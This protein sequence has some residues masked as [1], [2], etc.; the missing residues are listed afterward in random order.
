MKAGFFVIFDNVVGLISI[1]LF[2]N[3]Y[4]LYM[5][6][7]SR[8]ELEF[9]AFIALIFGVVQVSMFLEAIE[10]IPKGFHSFLNFVYV[11]YLSYILYRLL[12]YRKELEKSRERSENRIKKIRGR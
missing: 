5:E 2:A 1:F 3:F 7:R 6:N 12:E 10:V 4:K 9:A 11:I 8:K